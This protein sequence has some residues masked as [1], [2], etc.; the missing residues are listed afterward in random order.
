MS[1]GA[2][3]DTQPCP[4]GVECC[5]GTCLPNGYFCDLFC[6]NSDKQCFQDSDCVPKVLNGTCAR[7]VPVPNN[8]AVGTCPTTGPTAGYCCNGLVCC[9]NADQVC[10]TDHCITVCP[11]NTQPC[12]D[13]CCDPSFQTCFNNTCLVNCGATPCS[14]TQTCCSVGSQSV[15]CDTA[16]QVCGAQSGQCVRRATCTGTDVYIER[17]NICCPVASACGTTD[18]CDLLGG[19]YCDTATGVCRPTCTGTDVYIRPLNICCPGA[20]ACGTTDCC[21]GYGGFSPNTGQCNT[22]TGL[23]TLP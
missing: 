13:S 15:C 5:G 23:C 16:T 18:C 9:R 8:C 3:S 19:Q 21:N 6:T 1:S 2:C 10:P 14:D 7:Y 22:A 17:Q 20:D 12:G 4:D 11:Q